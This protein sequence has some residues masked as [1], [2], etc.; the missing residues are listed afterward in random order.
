MNKSL[1]AAPSEGGSAPTAHLTL[2]SPYR[3]TIYY[4]DGSTYEHAFDYMEDPF[5]EEIPIRRLRAGWFLTI[6][7]FQYYGSVVEMEN[8]LRYTSPPNISINNSIK[9]MAADP[10]ESIYYGIKDVTKNARL[11]VNTPYP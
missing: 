5:D 8:I 10:H 7:E 3:V 6:D 2:Y 9:P 1:L 4:V 11:H